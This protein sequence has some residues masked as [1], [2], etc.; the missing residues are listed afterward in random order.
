MNMELTA[1]SP[2]FSSYIWVWHA[3][4]GFPEQF[5]IPTLSFYSN[6]YKALI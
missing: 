6:Y 1:T 2:L 3:Y 4:L 5:N